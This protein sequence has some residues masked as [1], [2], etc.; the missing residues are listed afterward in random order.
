MSADAALARLRAPGAWFWLVLAAG[1]LLRVWLVTATLGTYDV[2]I[3][4]HHGRA[5]HELGL[6]EHYRRQPAFNHPPLAGAFFAAAD[7]L[8]GAS[9]VPFRVL[10]RA[11]FALLDAATAAALFALFRASPWRWAV[12]AGFWLHPLSWLF[13]SYHGNT[14]SFVALSALLAL[15]ATLHARPDL[16]GVAL[17]VGA[18]IKLPALL[19]APAIFLATR[20]GRA[21]AVFAL[22]TAAAGAASSLP[23]VSAEPALAAR[24]VLGYAGSGA[25]TVHGVPIWGVWTALGLGRLPGLGAVAAFATAN[26]TILCLSAILLVA[27]L[28]RSR[29]EAVDLGATVFASFMLLYGLSA[30]WAF[31]YLAWSAPFWFFR[32]RVYAVL[33]SLLLGGYVYG[34]YALYCG[35][36][37]LL[38]VWDHAGHPQWPAWLLLLRSAAVAFCAASALWILADAVRGALRARAAEAG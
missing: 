33:G 32:G 15:L 23:F 28:R 17:G 2:T 4:A 21:R 5:V 22:C 10:L 36:P 8:A 1:A 13:S 12:V 27:W 3:K 16:A 37:W 9:G 20:G 31:Q 11:P 19:A 35:N 6:I 18:A 34:V 24:N 38:G 30:T 7:A 14:D 29:R 26:N 25:A